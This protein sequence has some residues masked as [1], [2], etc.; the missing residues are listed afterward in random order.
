[1]RLTLSRVKELQQ[2]KS[3]HDNSTCNNPNRK[4]LPATIIKSYRGK[5]AGIK[6]KALTLLLISL[7]CFHAKQ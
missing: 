3:Q 5:N 2:N 6:K 4:H 7:I 1:M